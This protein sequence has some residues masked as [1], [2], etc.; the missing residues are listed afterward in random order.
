M[1]VNDQGYE[2][3]Q[4]PRTIAFNAWQ[5]GPDERLG[6]LS[7]RGSVS[8]PYELHLHTLDSH[9]ARFLRDSPAHKRT[10]YKI[11]LGIIQR[12]KKMAYRK[13]L[14]HANLASK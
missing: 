12:E 6:C 14:V 13:N 11:V 4:G 5:D 8:S 9:V 1:I 3:I 10:G 7:R 2:N